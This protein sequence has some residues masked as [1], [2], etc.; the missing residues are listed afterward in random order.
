MSKRGENI[1]KRKN[2]N[3]WE[4]RY[5]KSRDKSGKIIYGYV[6]GKTYKEVKE[7]KEAAIIEN[8]KHKRVSPDKCSFNDL[9]EAFLQQ[10][11]H[12]VKKSTY[13]N[14]KNVIKTHIE[15]YFSNI[16]MKNLTSTD[17]EDFTCEKLINGRKDGKGGLE[18]KTVKDMLSVLTSVLKYGV[19]KNIIGQDILNFSV[20]KC[21]NK[22]PQIFNENEVETIIRKAKEADEEYIFGIYLCLYTGLRIGEICALQWG[23]ID[24][25]RNVIKVSKTISR[26][27][28]KQNKTQIHIDRPKTESGYREIPIPLSIAPEIR[29][30]KKSDKAY[31]LTGKEEYLEPRRYYDKYRKFL[32]ECG[33]KP[34]SFHCIRHTFATHCVEIGFDP[35]TLSEILGHSDV[36]ITLDRYVHP[37]M[38]MKRSCMDLLAG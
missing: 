5:I 4:A 9:A 27:Y 7:K 15:P 16:E 31:V 6:Y 23:D 8:A 30:R 18:P 26:L 28:D 32:N 22:K 33:I 1:R 11:Q 35:K 29:N 2:D 20:P 12:Q 10:A 17:I 38:E 19:N 36:R 25:E 14:Y 21:Q 37:S 13:L 24:I 34:H 3:R